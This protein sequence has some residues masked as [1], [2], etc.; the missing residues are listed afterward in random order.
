MIRT[1]RALFSAECTSTAGY[2]ALPDA[3]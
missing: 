1:G 2:I 3:A